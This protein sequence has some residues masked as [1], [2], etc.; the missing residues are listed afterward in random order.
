MNIFIP[1]VFHVPTLNIRWINKTV[2]LFL[3]QTAQFK[4]MTKCRLFVCC[5][6]SQ[7]I[8]GLNSKWLHIRNSN[9]FTYM[10]AGSI[11]ILMAF[12]RSK[13]I[14]RW[15]TVSNTSTITSARALSSKYITSPSRRQTMQTTQQKL[16][17]SSEC[18]QLWT[19]CVWVCV[20]LLLLSWF[21]WFQCQ[22]NKK[23]LRASESVS[24]RISH[25]ISDFSS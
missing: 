9:Q 23:A 15:Q 18:D 25:E 1:I 14:C 19:A 5:C 13:S 10:I 17:L 11:L 2:E 6:L 4:S 12:K 24:S 21:L 8:Y 22:F 20:I 3:F 16:R 7:C